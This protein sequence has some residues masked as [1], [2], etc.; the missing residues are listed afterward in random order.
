MSDKLNV[1][2]KKERR[3]VPYGDI[4]YMEKFGRKII[5]HSLGGEIEFYGKFIEVMTQLDMRFSNPHESYL[6]NMDFI[7][8]IDEK[9]IDMERGFR[10][11]MGKKCL[12][13]AKKQYDEYIEKAKKCKACCSRNNRKKTCKQLNSVVHLLLALS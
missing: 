4:I 5:L 6:L 12:G 7:I 10:I 1:K 3:A 2:T 11:N 8:R 13:K 9:G